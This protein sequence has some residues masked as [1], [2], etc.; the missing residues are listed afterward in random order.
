VA[1]VGWRASGALR[2]LLMFGYI[3]TSV[4][5]GLGLYALLPKKKPL[6]SA[7]EIEAVTGKYFIQRKPAASSPE[8]YDEGAAGRLWEISTHLTGWNGVPATP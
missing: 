6:A 2:P 8:S 4:G 3:G 1:V 7:P 5:V